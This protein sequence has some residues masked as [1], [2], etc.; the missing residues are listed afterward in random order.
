MP[1]PNVFISHRW[2]SNQ[3]Y[4]GLTQKFAQYGF[5]F[6]NYSVPQHD[7]ADATR[8]G[9]IKAMLAEQVRQCN[10]FIIFANMAISN[11]R[12]C[13]F[14][15][16]CAVGYNKPILSVNPFGYAGGTPSRIASAGNQGGPVGFNAPSIV[17][18]ICRTLSWPIPF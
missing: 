1:K 13:M 5:G 11:S 8:V 10:Y 18:K 7:P 17:R 6:L 12:W 3:N 4:Y 16:E 15:L 9:I 14:E 2:D